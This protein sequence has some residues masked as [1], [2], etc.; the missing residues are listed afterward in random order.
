[1]QYTCYGH[2]DRNINWV[3][4]SKWRFTSL[5]GVILDRAIHYMAAMRLLMGDV[6][7]AIG[8]SG[9][10]RD[11]I[12]PMDYLALHMLFEN[13]TIG[14]L[15]D[16]ASV[17]GISKREIIVVGSEGTIVLSNQL[18]TISVFNENGFHISKDYKADRAESFI[19]EFIDFY[20]SI[21][22]GTTNKSSFFDGYKD[23][24]LAITGISTNSRWDELGLLDEFNPNGNS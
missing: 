23:L 10:M 2:Y 20:Q 18:T 19:R 22:E 7:S 12:G 16:I 5:G 6:K 13:G 17:T 21:T 8:R 4:D 15:L 3:K 11:D 1:M 9:R 24:Q 14:S